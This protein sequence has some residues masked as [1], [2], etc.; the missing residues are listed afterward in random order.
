MD[1][2][3]GLIVAC[4]YYSKTLRIERGEVNDFIDFFTSLDGALTFTLSFPRAIAVTAQGAIVDTGQEVVASVVDRTELRSV[5]GQ[6]P[7]TA[8]QTSTFRFANS[9]VVDKFERIFVADMV[10]KKL[11]EVLA[12][13]SIAAFAGNGMDPDRPASQ[14]PLETGVGMVAGL[15]L[16]NDGALL[17]SNYGLFPM[18]KRF[19]RNANRFVG[20]VGNGKIDYVTPPIGS[21]LQV[22]LGSPNDI[23]QL[24]DGRIAFTDDSAP[25]LMVV[26]ADGHV[27]YLLSP[28]QVGRVAYLAL[29]SSG[30]LALFDRDAGNILLYVPEA[31]LAGRYFS[32]SDLGNA[33]SMSEIRSLAF[34]G[35]DRLYVASAKKVVRLVQGETPTLIAGIG[36]PILSGTSRDDGLDAIRDI[37]ISAAGHLYIL[38]EERLKRVPKDRLDRI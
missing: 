33:M 29:R 4:H 19:E 5:V 3:N 20:V 17:F 26:T 22:A 7:L 25:G 24:E 11:L 12:D 16:A 31:G 2:A 34:D 36:A 13:G 14:A 23:A 30:E 37:A 32:Q 35:R 27:D 15:A 1:N 18:I 10:A 6:L 21:A 8:N 28:S 38:E 9:I